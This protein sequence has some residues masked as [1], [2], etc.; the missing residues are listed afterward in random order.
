MPVPLVIAGAFGIVAGLHSAASASR[1]FVAR[2]LKRHRADIEQWALSNAFEAMGLPDLDKS[3]NREQFT[4]A[5]NAHFLAGSEFQLSNAFDAKAVR[6]DAMRYALKKAAH[7]L[8]V[9]LGHATVAAMKDALKQW[10][11]DQVKAQIEAGGGTLID[12]AKDAPRVMAMIEYAQS[13]PPVPGLLMTPEA[14]SNRERQARYRANHSKHW[15]A[16][17]S[18]RASST[19]DAGI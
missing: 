5:I 1:P 13:R 14:I 11:Q 4:E 9:E 8:G 10:I 2:F 3:P 19:Y 12:G 16:R 17:G 6:E 18:A 7:E 15:E